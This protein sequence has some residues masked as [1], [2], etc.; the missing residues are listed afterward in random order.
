MATAPEKAQAASKRR[1]AKKKPLLLEALAE[2]G[3]NVSDACKKVGISRAT[4]YDYTTSDPEFA[5]QVEG[6]KEAKLD[7]AESILWDHIETGNIAALLFYLKCQ[8]KARGWVE[9]SEVT[10][11]TTV[12]FID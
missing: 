8:G 4:F 1:R 11:A 10:Q 7:Q 12:E 5:T 2:N 6:V 9:K 3:G